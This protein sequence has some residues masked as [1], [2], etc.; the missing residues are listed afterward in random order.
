MQDDAFVEQLRAQLKTYTEARNRADHIATAWPNTDI[1]R[2]MAD[3]RRALD[4]AIASVQQ[5]LK[6]ERSAA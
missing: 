4:G 3:F 5:A 2:E 6:M 1:G